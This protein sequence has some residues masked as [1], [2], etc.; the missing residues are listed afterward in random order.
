[1]KATQ[2]Y[3]S[4]VTVF[5]LVAML[6]LLIIWIGGYVSW[7][8]SIKKLQNNSQQQ[9]DQFVSHFDAHLARFQFVPQLITKNQ[10]LVELLKQPDNSPR[11]NVVNHFLEDINKI[12]GASDTYLMDNNGL[13]LA[14]SNWQTEHSFVGKNF[15]F[16][17][18]FRQAMA[19]HLGRYF[20]LGS[21]SAKR[22]YY[23][24]YPIRYAAQNVGVIV[25]KMDLSD[26]ELQWSQRKIQF[27]IT[28][29]EGVIFIS[30]QSNWLYHAIKP[31]SS[32]TRKEIHVSQRYSGQQIKS[33]ALN[34]LHSISQNI[35]ILQVDNQQQAVND[36]YLGIQKSMPHAG[37]SA[38]IL[39]PLNEVRQN[40]I[41]TIVVL[42]LSI[43][44]LL[45]VGFLAWQRYKRQQEK[46]FSQE[47]A[48]KQLENEVLVRTADL[49]DEIEEHKR[50][51]NELIQTAKLA[52]LGE[53]SANISHELN[54]PL[55][56]IQS[57]AENARQFLSM[58]KPEKVDEN[59][60]RITQLTTRMSK[61]ISQLKFFSR[62]SINALEEINL[63]VVIQ[64]AV[65]IVSTQIKDSHSIIEIN[66]Q[67][68]DLRAHADIIQLEQILINLINNALQAIEN[69]EIGKIII[70]TELEKDNV[71]IHVQDNGPGIDTE[72]FNKIFDPFFTTK[73]TGLGLGLSISARIMSC[74]NGQLS[75]QNIASGGAI[76]TITLPVLR[77][78]IDSFE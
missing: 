6:M 46:E 18:Y 71:L 49:R 27:I 26:I 55:A 25:V 73:K 11:I 34:K 14:A 16:R 41:M 66:N 39:A 47:E 8:I 13:T 76:F 15:N 17:P 22:G 65:D 33:L 72:N 53:M 29:P 24:A 9:L 4:K 5:F 23:F 31:L 67:L 52:V 37:W 44:L 7:N 78:N 48:K 10:L 51:Q 68:S 74:M 20:A 45:L 50:T 69:V 21:T 77:E 3:L 64:S 12:I 43:L 28:D 70:Y 38:M 19:G 42:F 56:A 63:P 61:I 62:K 36:D 75:A 32:E 30:T 2:S 35:N 40:I 1:M 54:N 57:Y 58:S 60:S 59:L